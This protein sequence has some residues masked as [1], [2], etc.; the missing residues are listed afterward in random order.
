MQAGYDYCRMKLK[1]TIQV[2][3]TVIQML[4]PLENICTMPDAKGAFYILLRLKSDLSDVKIVERLI[5]EYQVAVLPG[6]AFGITGLCTIRLS[7]GPLQQDTAAQGVQRLVDCL[8]SI[9]KN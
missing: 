9:I 5:R 4:E 8:V 1:Q 3:E 6:S 2:R 7:Y